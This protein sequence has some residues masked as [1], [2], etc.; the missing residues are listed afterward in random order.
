MMCQNHLRNSES[1]LDV[2][3]NNDGIQNN[4][5][6]L[7]LKPTTIETPDPWNNSKGGGLHPL[8]HPDNRSR[9]L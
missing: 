1:I 8:K 9:Q 5:Y 7:T 6:L 2:L 4:Q 3:Y